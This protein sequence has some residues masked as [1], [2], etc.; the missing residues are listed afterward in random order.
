MSENN[1]GENFQ[2]EQA[3]EKNMDS[4]QSQTYALE[5]ENKL[6]SGN[7]QKIEEIKGT[8]FH[9]LHT[10]MGTFITIGNKVVTEP[11]TEE[12]CKIMIKEKFWHLIVS[13]ITVVTERTTEAL[14][15]EE[16]A[17]NEIGKQTTINDTFNRDRY[18]N[19]ENYN[20][21]GSKKEVEQK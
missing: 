14:K 6:N 10:E 7:I 13:V 20:E 11:H 15:L 1:N 5:M 8:P 12:E 2:M 21:D 4:Q 19:P 16:K 3:S 9:L 17:R 18:E